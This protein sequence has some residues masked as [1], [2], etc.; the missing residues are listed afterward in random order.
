VREL[1]FEIR[2]PRREIDIVRGSGQGLQLAGVGAAGPAHIIDPQALI[3]CK[4][5]IELDGGCDVGIVVRHVD[6]LGGIEA[7]EG[8]KLDPRTEVDVEFVVLDPV[9][10][11]QPVGIGSELIRIAEEAVE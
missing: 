11:G 8:H 6:A 2:V 10:D 1:R 9:G 7:V 3:I 5:V 4:R